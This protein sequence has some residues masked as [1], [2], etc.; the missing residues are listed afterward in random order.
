[1]K[2]VAETE[3]KHIVAIPE[4]VSVTIVAIEPQIVIVVFDIEQFAVAIGISYIQHA[5]RA[6]TL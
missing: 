3:D 4:V 6:T 2:R 5:I 1:M